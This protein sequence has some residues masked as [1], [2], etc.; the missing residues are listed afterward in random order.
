VNFGKEGNKVLK[1]P[2]QPSYEDLGRQR[3]R[4]HEDHPNVKLDIDL[5]A[6]TSEDRGQTADL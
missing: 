1:A 3:R 5:D 6:M 2:A 4:F